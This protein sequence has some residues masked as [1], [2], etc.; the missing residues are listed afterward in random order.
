MYDAV[1]A[2]FTQHEELKKLLL[3]TGQAYLIE[4]T[5]NDNY[6][7]DGGNGKGGNKLGK[8]LMKVREKIS[9]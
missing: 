6:W 9:E 4:H 5:V 7:G 8:V 1:F 3:K 2:K